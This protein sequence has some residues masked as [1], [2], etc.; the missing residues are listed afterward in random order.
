MA[1][2]GKVALELRQGIAQQVTSLLAPQPVVSAVLVIGS[3]AS[4]HVD[5]R[6]DVD[7][8]VILDKKG[9]SSNYK[10]ILENKK[11][12]SV[13]LREL[14]KTVPVDLLVYTRDEWT[15][16]KNSGSSFIQQIEME[17]IRLI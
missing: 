9:I 3:V 12:V 6:S 10:E 2:P 15:I 7:L 5:E 13:H 1:A 4:G 14:R 11:T 17:G 8:L 16:L